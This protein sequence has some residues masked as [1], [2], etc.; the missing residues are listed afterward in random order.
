[1]SRIVQILFALAGSTALIACGDD[2][3]KPGELVVNWN[4]GPTGATC[5]TFQITTLAVRVLKGTEELYSGSG[6]CSPEATKGSITIKDVKPGT[7]KIELDGR[8]ATGRATYS[9]GLAKQN[10]SEGKTVESTVIELK[11]KPATITV[12]WALPGNDRC[13]TVGITDLEFSLYYDA[14]VAPNLVSTTK[15]KCDSDVFDLTGLV[16]NND[17]KIVAAGLNAAKKKIAL[18][19]TE[20]FPLTAGDELDK[21][22]AFE[23]CPGDPPLCP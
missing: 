15:V 19:S 3:V 13:A 20:F 8:D 16:P 17:V 11:L 7:Y 9:G 18:G 21:K 5:G 14:S 2:P 22:I 23:F 6:A 12:D 4:T 1:M 10:V